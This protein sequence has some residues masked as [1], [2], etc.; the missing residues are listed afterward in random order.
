MSDMWAALRDGADPDAP[1]MHGWTALHFAAS[2][3]RDDPDLIRIL[4]NEGS[5]IESADTLSGWTL[6][7][8]LQER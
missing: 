8:L 1:D 2:C 7:M 5:D 6:S 3:G 4:I